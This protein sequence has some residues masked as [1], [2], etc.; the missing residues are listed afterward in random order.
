ATTVR[1]DSIWQENFV[2]GDV[3]AGEYELIITFADVSYKRDVEILPGQ[4]SFEVIATE[5]SYNPTSTPIPLPTPFP[6]IMLDGTVPADG[7]PLLTTPTPE[8]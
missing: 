4:T 5:F 2:I 6:T 3:P 7:L 1:P 8:S